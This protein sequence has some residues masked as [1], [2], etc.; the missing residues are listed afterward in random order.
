MIRYSSGNVQQTIRVWSLEER[1]EL[2]STDEDFGLKVRG[3]LLTRR[4]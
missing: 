4:Q 1:L 3:S 2:G